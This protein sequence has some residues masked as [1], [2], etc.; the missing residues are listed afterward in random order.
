MR[1]SMLYALALDR[2]YNHS[3]SMN[4]LLIYLTIIPYRTYLHSRLPQQQE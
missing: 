3:E 1:S 4:S 2:Q